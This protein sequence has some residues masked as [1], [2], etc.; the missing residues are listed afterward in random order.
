MVEEMLRATY[1]E[2]VFTT[3]IRKN[4]SVA[5]APL[6]SKDILAYAPQSNGAKDYRA[7]VDEILSR[8]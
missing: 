8:V 1:G 2:I 7:L 4:V 6:H 3:K 5:E